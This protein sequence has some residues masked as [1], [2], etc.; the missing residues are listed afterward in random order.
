MKLYYGLAMLVQLLLAFLFRDKYKAA[1]ILYLWGS[2]FGGRRDK[3][4]SSRPGLAYKKQL[5]RFW[6]EKYV[7]L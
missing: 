6:C 1:Y 2:V 7:I 3:M 5:S 4:G